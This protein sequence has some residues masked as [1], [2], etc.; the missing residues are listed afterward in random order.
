[1]ADH[2]EP[3][4]NAPA[5]NKSETTPPAEVDQL[6]GPAQDSGLIDN[7]YDVEVKL[8]DLQQNPD[9]TLYSA[10][11]FQDMNLYVLPPSNESQTQHAT[12]ELPCA[13]P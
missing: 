3:E 4:A 5:E 11:S 2:T 9:S 6:D 8:G 1:M 12:D 7:S 10:Q 13:Q